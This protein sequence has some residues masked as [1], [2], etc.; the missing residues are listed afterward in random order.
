MLSDT[1]I[2]RNK[3]R[4][5]IMRAWLKVRKKLSQSKR[6][7]LNRE[8]RAKLDG[9]EFTIFANNCLGGVFYH[10]AGK[11]FTSPTINMAFDGEDFIKLC[12]NPKHYFE[13]D[14]FEFFTWQGH[15]YP[16]ARIDDIEGRF[17]HYH[18]K[19]ECIKKWKTRAGRVVWDNIFII[20]TD[21]D[22][23]YQE[24]WMKRFNNLP[25]KNKIMFVAKEWPQY[26]WAIRVPAFKRRHCVHILTDFANVHGQR[27]Y[28]TAFD[29]A[30]WIKKCSVCK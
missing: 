1:S 18:T 7:E 17:V 3:D 29:I 27:Y 21:V 19:E 15:D 16:L 4:S 30:G 5:I 13:W 23:M 22:G 6:E 11:Q 26:D 12:E 8:I 25:Y 28:E 9:V 24:Q 14:D 2:V 10:D 20:A